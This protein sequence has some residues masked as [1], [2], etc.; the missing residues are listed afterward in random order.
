[1]CVLV[2][3]LCAFKLVTT[4]QEATTDCFLHGLSF[5]YARSMEDY[6]NESKRATLFL[7]LVKPC[8]AAKNALNP[9]G[10]AIGKRVSFR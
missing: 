5:V 8:I 9:Q 7:W 4:A 10:K 1:M 6:H 2:P 3:F